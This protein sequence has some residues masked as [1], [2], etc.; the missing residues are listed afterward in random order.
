MDATS[1]TDYTATSGTVTLAPGATTQAIAVVIQGDTANN[2][3]E[4]FTVIL[5][6]PTNS[7][8]AT[9]TGTGTISDISPTLSINN[10][11]ITAPLTGTTTDDFTVTL[12]AASNKAVTVNYATSNGSATSP[13][14]YTATSGTLTIAA[15]QTTGIIPVPIQGDTANNPPETFNVT[16]SSPTHATITSPVGVGTIDDISPTLS[17]NNT[18]VTAPLTGTTTDNFTVTLSA[19]SSQAVTVNYTT[20]NGTATSPTDFTAASGTLTIAA[21]EDNGTSLSPFKRILPITLLKR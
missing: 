9:G 14:D 3:P 21:D 16:L 5:G 7:T 12:S 2:P 15:G 13:T 6:S 18:T 20:N 17:I 8:I 19:A 11:T 1:P 10:T 4:T